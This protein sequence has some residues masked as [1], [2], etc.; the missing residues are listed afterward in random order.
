MVSKYRAVGRSEN[1]GVPVLFGGHNLPKTGGAMAPPAPPRTTGL[2]Y[3]FIQKGVHFQRILFSLLAGSCSPINILSSCDVSCGCHILQFRPSAARQSVSLQ[4]VSLQFV[5]H[6]ASGGASAKQHILKYVVICWT[7][8]CNLPQPLLWMRSTDLP[9]MGQ[10][11]SPLLFH[12][13]RP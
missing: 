5:S 8:I 2:I 13:F 12:C 4:F 11:L 9:K 3:F 10:Q 6:S 7:Y 1:P